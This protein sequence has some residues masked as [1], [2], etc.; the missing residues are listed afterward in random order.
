MNRRRSIQAV[1]RVQCGKCDG[2]LG[3]APGTPA[4]VES[5]AAVFPGERPAAKAA[6]D[7]GWSVDRIKPP[8]SGVL[9]C[10]DCK[11]NPLGIVLPEQTRWPEPVCVC[12]HPWHTHNHLNIICEAEPGVLGCGCPGWKEKRD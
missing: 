4:T 8:G 5:S 6:R 9:L 3:R 11:T 7:A 12:T 10:Q 2:W 1:F